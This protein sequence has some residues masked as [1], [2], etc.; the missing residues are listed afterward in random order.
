M[1]PP[2][3][4]SVLTFSETHLLQINIISK[5]H[6]FSVDLKNLK[7]SGCIWNADVH[8]SVK[9]PWNQERKEKTKK[10]KQFLFSSKVEWIYS[11]W[12]N[13]NI[14]NV[15]FSSLTESPESWVNAVGS[16][17]SRHN[18]DVSPLLQ[19]VH[20][21][22]QLRHNAPLHFT[23]S[24][25]NKRTVYSQTCLKLDNNTHT[26]DQRLHYSRETQSRSILII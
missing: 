4:R 21:S 26:T 24:L 2:W 14:A 11:N 10:N 3:A 17:G 15:Q 19:S 22:E 12:L 23:M 7:S 16:V 18:N 13:S 20:Q 25:R 8:L 6:V 9:A 5:L 1:N